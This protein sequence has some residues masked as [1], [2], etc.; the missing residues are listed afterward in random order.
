MSHPKLEALSASLAAAPKSAELRAGII[1]DFIREPI[2][3]LIDSIGLEPFIAQVNMLYDQYVAPLD[4]PWVPNIVEPAVDQAVKSFL[5]HVIRK[6]HD[7]IH[8]E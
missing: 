1:D 4:I 3:D 6:L 5:G 8:T 7:K 2:D